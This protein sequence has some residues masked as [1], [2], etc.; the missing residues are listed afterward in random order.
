MKSIEE[1]PSNSN[2]HNAVVVVCVA[3]V[4]LQKIANFL[5]NISSYFDL[6]NIKYLQKEL[7]IIESMLQQ[8]NLTHKTFCLKKKV[9]NYCE[10]LVFTS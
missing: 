5:Y 7:K 4:H 2:F 3:Y 10:I 6:S 1:N 9:R 8:A